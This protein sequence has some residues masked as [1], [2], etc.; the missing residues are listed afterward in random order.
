MSP[1]ASL[2]KLKR[3]LS[4][5][6]EVM[7]GVCAGPESSSFLLFLAPPSSEVISRKDRIDFYMHM[8]HLGRNQWQ[9][10]CM[11]FKYG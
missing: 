4:W 3:F 1:E 8:L 2:E 11:E 9:K 6:A 5:E 7:E 10:D